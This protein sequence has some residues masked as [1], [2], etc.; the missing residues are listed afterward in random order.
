MPHIDAA[1]PAEDEEQQPESLEQLYRSWGILDLLGETMESVPAAWL[2]IMNIARHLLDGKRVPGVPEAADLTALVERR[3]NVRYERRM[4]KRQIA[5]Q[6]HTEDDTPDTRPIDDFSEFPRIIPSQRMWQFINPE[7][8]FYRIYTHDVLIREMR[9]E[10]LPDEDS[11]EMVEELVPIYERSTKP[12]QK[13]LVLRD[14]SSS[15]RDNNKGV[16][17]K[18]VAL[19]YLIKA[20]EEGAVIG[21]RSYANNVHPRIIA[22]S[23]DEFGTV[24]RRILKEGYYGT[25]N[26][27][28]AL[29]ITMAEIRR[30]ELG[31]DPYAKAKTEIL[32]ISDCENPEQLP[33]LPPGVVVNTLHLEGGREGLMLRDY[34]DRLQEIRDISDTFVR[35]DTSALQLPST[36]REAWL[37]AEEAKQLHEEDGDDDREGVDE[38]SERR[39]HMRRLETMARVYQRMTA[40]TNEQRAVGLYLGAMFGRREAGAGQLLRALLATWTRLVNRLSTA[41]TTHRTRRG[42][43][44]KPH[45]YVE[46]FLVR[47][48]G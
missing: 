4:V 12:R 6:E 20:Q 46:H 11:S 10:R 19:A 17:A 44:P 30:E 48:K 37:L 41:A 22:K 15:M 18:A 7:L 34:Q 32:L 1:P 42:N 2:Q 5:R 36:T 25:T 21:D 24:A 27:A 23:R 14:T 40:G 39:E 33:P 3:S 47:P 26:L 8:F 28:A 29:E 45:A 9:P 16:F 38:S 31:L 13:V 35:I 43:A